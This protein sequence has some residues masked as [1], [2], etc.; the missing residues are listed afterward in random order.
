MRGTPQ[1]DTHIVSSAQCLCAFVHCLSA[2]VASNV[3]LHV[4]V[5]GLSVHILVIWKDLESDIQQTVQAG[6]DKCWEI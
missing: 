3:L 1:R 4:V 6:L 5:V 2:T